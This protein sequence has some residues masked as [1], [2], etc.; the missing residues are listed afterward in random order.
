MCCLE[1]TVNG[2][3]ACGQLPAG[4]GVTLFMGKRVMGRQLEAAGALQDEPRSC[5]AGGIAELP[6]LQW[7]GPCTALNAL[8][9]MKQQRIVL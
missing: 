6:E 4:L 9:S 2:L 1:P 7:G 5:K 8:P 3:P